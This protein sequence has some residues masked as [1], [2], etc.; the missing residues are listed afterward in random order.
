MSKLLEEAIA[1]LAELPEEEQDSIGSWLL[2]ELESETRWDALL[3]ESGTALGH[4][5][6]DALAELRGGFTKELD[7]DK[8]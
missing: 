2:E 8:L 6:D 7:P 1:K 4:L 3:A 5:A